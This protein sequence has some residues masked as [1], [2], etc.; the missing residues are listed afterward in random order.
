VKV[1]VAMVTYRRAWA[2]PH[3]L[4]SIASQT[5]KPDEVLIVL[6]PSGDGS[7]DVI[8]S[9][10][11]QLP[12]KLVVQERGNFTDAVQMAIDNAEG[13]V[14][15]FL[16]DDAVA[17]ERWVEKYEN[18]FNSLPNVGGVSGATYKAYIEN[19][20][21]VKTYEPFYDEKP[22]KNTF[23]RKPLPEYVNYYGWISRSGFMGAKA[24]PGDVFLST[25][26]DG[27]NMGLL[28]KAVKDCPLAELFKRSRKGIWNE[29]ILAYCAKKKGY[30]TYKALGPR[31][32]SAWHLV[33]ADSLTRGRGFWHEFWLHYDRVVNYWR[34]KKLGAQVSPYAYL[35]ACLASLRRRLLPRLLATLYGWLVRL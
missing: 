26:L 1:T 21:I 20:K 18:L 32:P 6:K 23:Y 16:D 19:G 8:R 2:L 4:A 12:I 31:A 29:K 25:S 13:D 14:I 34:L 10:S 9:F 15:L 7:E 24:Q 5:R 30:D 33:H 22:T 27:V 35:A 11:S 17:E 28:R 3:S